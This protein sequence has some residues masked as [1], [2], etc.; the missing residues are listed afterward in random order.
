VE[1]GKVEGERRV[2]IRDGKSEIE[3]PEEV[4]KVWREYKKRGEV[5]K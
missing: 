3:V 1:P 4:M 2:I 5:G